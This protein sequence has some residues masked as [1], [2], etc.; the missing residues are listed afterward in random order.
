MAVCGVS[1][2]SQAPLM[3]QLLLQLRCFAVVERGAAFS[4]LENGIRIRE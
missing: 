3:H 4:A 1:W 2:R